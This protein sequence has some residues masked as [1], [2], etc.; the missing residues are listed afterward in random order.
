MRAGEP[1]DD[2]KDESVLAGR[3][4][5][6]VA[7]GATKGEAS[8]RVPSRGGPPPSLAASIATPAV[9]Q[10]TA[11]NAIL[12]IVI[13]L[14]GKADATLLAHDASCAIGKNPFGPLYLRR[15][16]GCAQR[17]IRLS[18]ARVNAGKPRSARV[19]R[20]RPG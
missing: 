8:A 20:I 17:E 12:V 14:P 16:Q 7:A 3:G 2:R 1:A 13:S 5:D 10:V 15:K 6:V 11:I 19:G 18:G 4:A 9:T